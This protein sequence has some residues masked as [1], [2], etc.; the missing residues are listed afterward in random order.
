MSNI[1]KIRKKTNNN[2]IFLDGKK[3][4]DMDYFDLIKS[5]IG[6]KLVEIS[7]IKDKNSFSFKNKPK[8]IGLY[9]FNIKFLIL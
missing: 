2:F 4:I 6:N 1:N 8:N 5:K 3:F 7:L 9:L